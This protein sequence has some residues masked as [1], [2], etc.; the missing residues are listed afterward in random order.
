MNIMYGKCNS[1]ESIDYFFLVKNRV[2]QTD[3]YIPFGDHWVFAFCQPS[4]ILD[5][6]T[7]NYQ[8]Y[9]N[10]CTMCVYMYVS[11]F[12]YTYISECM[13]EC[14]RCVHV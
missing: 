1:P 9:V 6:C 13:T 12:I 14:R 11:I 2:V 3:V 4:C 8:S 7:G 10:Y 5:I